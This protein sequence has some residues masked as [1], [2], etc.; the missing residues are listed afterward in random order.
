M[1][2]FCIVAVQRLIG[3]AKH[4]AQLALSEKEYRCAV[5]ALLT[6]ISLDDNLYIGQH[7][8]L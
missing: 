5:E 2:D 6:V 1:I 7:L 4:I 8:I 3:A